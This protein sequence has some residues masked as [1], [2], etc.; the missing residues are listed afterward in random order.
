MKTNGVIMI[1]PYVSL[2]FVFDFRKIFILKDDRQRLR[3]CVRKSET[4]L[5]EGKGEAE[6]TFLAIPEPGKDDHPNQKAQHIPPLLKG[7]R[8]E[9]PYLSEAGNNASVESVPVP[10]SRAA[11]TRRDK[12]TEEHP[13][14]KRDWPKARDK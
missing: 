2:F 10:F 5:A 8:T 6:V 3:L 11:K 7:M 9:A 14:Q 4:L 13:N 12:A 1:S